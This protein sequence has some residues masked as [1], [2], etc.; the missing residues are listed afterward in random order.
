MS[1]GYLNIFKNQ[2]CKEVKMKYNILKT[3]IFTKFILYD[4]MNMIN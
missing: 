3:K 1:I 4:I 2:C